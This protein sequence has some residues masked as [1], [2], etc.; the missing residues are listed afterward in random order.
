MKLKELETVKGLT[1][2]HHLTEGEWDGSGNK[3][4]T[5][6]GTSISPNYRNKYHYGMY[7]GCPKC[8]AIRLAIKRNTAFRKPS[9]VNDV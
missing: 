6:C 2:F 8:E 1:G 9:G 4:K 5:L 3:L 7:L